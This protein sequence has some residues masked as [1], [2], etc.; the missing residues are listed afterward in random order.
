MNTRTGVEHDTTK[1]I[2]VHSWTN[3][4]QV[5]WEATGSREVE[6]PD[7]TQ[8]ALD[9]CTESLAYL[10]TFISLVFSS[11]FMTEIYTAI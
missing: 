6:L 10:F 5:D 3:Q 9:I 4:H 1:A 11:I 8:N 7:K 2:A